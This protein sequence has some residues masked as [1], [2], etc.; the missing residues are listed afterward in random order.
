MLESSVLWTILNSDA[1]ARAR[2][3]EFCTGKLERVS[4]ASPSTLFSFCLFPTLA[5]PLLRDTHAI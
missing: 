2:A 4:R 5:P 1:R 3:P